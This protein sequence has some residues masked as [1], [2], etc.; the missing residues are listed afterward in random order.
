MNGIEQGIRIMIY[1]KIY[2]GKILPI[3]NVR[4]LINP[5]GQYERVENIAQE[6]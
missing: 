4:Q 6:R 1:I 3:G 5:P 2:K